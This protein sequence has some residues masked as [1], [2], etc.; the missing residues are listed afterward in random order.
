MLAICRVQISSSQNSLKSPGSLRHRAAAATASR[1]GRAA[2]QVARADSLRPRSSV[3]VTGRLRSSFDHHERTKLSEG[4][5]AY[6]SGFPRRGQKSRSALGRLC[7]SPGRSARARGLRGRGSRRG[8]TPSATQAPR[9]GSERFG[10]RGVRV[11]GGGGRAGAASPDARRALCT[12]VRGVRASLARSAGWGSRLLLRERRL[13]PH[14]PDLLLAGH[15]GVYRS[16]LHPQ[17]AVKLTRYG[18][19]TR[20]T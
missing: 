14:A 3:S 19:H 18:S 5:R 17:N 9:R 1:A 6:N 2:C 15:T 13:L 12:G 11:D 20:G 10:H 16:T 7:F 4:V 8:G